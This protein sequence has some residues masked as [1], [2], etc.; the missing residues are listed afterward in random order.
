MK[1]TLL[2]TG[3]SAGIPVLTCRCVVCQSQDFRDKRLRCAALVE[4]PDAVLAIDAGPDFRQQLLRAAPPTLDAV[5]FTHEHKDHVAGLDDI[6]PF[7]FLQG[8]RISVYAT[9]RVEA[10]LRREYHY[11]FSG[12]EYP[13]IPEIQLHRIDEKPFQVA[14]HLITPIQ[15]MHHKLPVLGFRIGNFAY[16]TDANRIEEGEFQKL[17]GLDVLILNALRRT[18]HIS[19]FSLDEAIALAQRIGARFTYFTHISHQM[20]LHAEVEAQLLPGMGLA[21]DGLIFLWDI[22]GS[23][24]INHRTKGW[25]PE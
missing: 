17:Q 4:W 8:K 25:L 23:V 7:N 16:I 13:G 9:E 10:A 5:V 14:G 20:G 21:Y 24:R 19:H 3:T 22:D 2:G 1:V 6:R 11:I 18:P 15:A 12:E